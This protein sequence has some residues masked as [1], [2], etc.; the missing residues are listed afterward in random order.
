METKFSDTLRAQIHAFQTTF[1]TPIPELSL[2][3]HEAGELLI[4]RYGLPTHFNGTPI[5]VTCT[6]NPKPSVRP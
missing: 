3:R 4:E 5:I 1:G 6:A 2:T